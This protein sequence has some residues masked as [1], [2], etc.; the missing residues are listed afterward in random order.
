MEEEETKEIAKRIFTGR[1]Y[2]PTDEEVGR[3]SKNIFLL[4]EAGLHKLNKRLI[5]GGR[6]IWDTFVEH[7]F[8][9]ELVLLH[10][11]AM[12][13]DYEPEDLQ[14]RPDLRII[15]GE[16]TYW[17]QIKNLTDLERDSRRNKMMQDLKRFGKKIKV[18]KFFECIL[19]DNFCEGDLEGLKQFL[20]QKAPIAQ[21]GEE[22]GF[23][24]ET[25]PTAKLVFWSPMGLPISELTM[26]LWRDM[27]VVS[28]TGLSA[29]QIKKAVMN[30]SAAFEWGTATKNINIV[31]MNAD[32]YHDIDLCDALFGTEYEFDRLDEHGVFHQRWSRKKDGLL[33]DEAFSKKVAGVISLR[34]K[35]K[36][37]PVTE[38]TR[39][40]YANERYLVYADDIRKVIPFSI[41]ARY[42]T[43]PPM[44]KAN[45]GEP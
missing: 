7:N 38:Y 8:A 3:L 13:I 29:D 22:Y 28:I 5:E 43:R 34:S 45:F 18:G 30:S 42:N 35:E 4:R 17:I 26:G 32:K 31:A 21:E 41:L 6:K 9:A 25:T 19:S 23:P 33:Y 36:H 24:S 11:K 12:K 27:E 16:R 14:H 15:Y 44:G 1:R 39:I 2:E 10:G 40:F 37:S 20:S